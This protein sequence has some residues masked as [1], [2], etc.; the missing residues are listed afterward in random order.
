LFRRGIP[1]RSDGTYAG[2]ENLGRIYDRAETDPG[3]QAFLRRI[4]VM[5]DGEWRAV[6]G[7]SK[8]LAALRRAKILRAVERTDPDA[9]EAATAAILEALVKPGDLPLLQGTRMAAVRERAD[10][11]RAAG[12]ALLARHQIERADFQTLYEAFE[13]VLPASRLLSATDAPETRL[14]E[15]HDGH[16]C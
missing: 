14:G 13:G 16:V 3:F 9:R 11:A 6:L 7:R 1:P 15:S 8:G 5:S 10:A 4:A 12:E 2:W